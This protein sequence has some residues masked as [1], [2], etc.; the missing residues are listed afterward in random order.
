MTHNGVL[1]LDE[2]PEFR[3][4]VLE[5]LRQPL[6]SGK[7]EISRVNGSETFPC[8]FM[9][10]TAMNPC[11]CGNY[12]NPVKPCT[13]KPAD[14]KK[15]H[16]KISGPLLE[17]IDMQIE[18]N[19]LS[20][21]DLSDTDRRYESS[22]EIRARVNKARKFAIERFW[23]AAEKDKSLTPIRFNAAMN[24]RHINRFCHLDGDALAIMQT[25]HEKFQLSGRGYDRILRVA[26]TIADL[27]ESENIQK[28]HISEAIQYRGLEK[29]YF[30]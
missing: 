18:V 29:K 21:N 17:R 14:V 24:D 15:Y 27:A 13:C 22:A 25:A 1:F 4:D 9:F 20:F 23:S 3:Q 19:A 26:R 7:V 30:F 12:G 5:V 28:N 11:K 10:V 2:L 16:S 8:S 6:E